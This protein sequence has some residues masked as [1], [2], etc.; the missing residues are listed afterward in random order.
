MILISRKLKLHEKSGWRKL[1][2][3]KKNFWG[4][5]T[6]EISDKN[7]FN[8][9]EGKNS[10][11]KELEAT[12]SLFFKADVSTKCNFIAR[13]EWLKKQLTLKKKKLPPIKCKEFEK[14][15]Q[16]I[17][18][19]K[20]SIVF[21]FY[22]MDEPAS[23][24]G[25]TFLRLYSSKRGE[26][27]YAVSYIANV[28][29]ENLLS[30]IFKGIFGGFQ[31]SFHI[32]PFE[33]Q[34]NQYTNIENRSVWEYKL[35]LSERETSRLLMH[36]WELS[37]IHFSYFFFDRN[38]SYQL[39]TLI[40]TARPFLDISSD[41]LYAVQPLDTVKTLKKNNLIDINSNYSNYFPSLWD[42]YQRGVSYLTDHEIEYLKDIL[43]RG[44]LP[45]KK[46][47][48]DKRLQVINVALKY[49]QYKNWKTDFKDAYY[50]KLQVKLFVEYNLLKTESNS[51][52]NLSLSAS[53]KQASLQGVTSKDPLLSHNS[54]TVILSSRYFSNGFYHS[55]TIRPALKDFFDYSFGYHPYSQLLILSTNFIYYP[56]F[57]FKSLVLLD[58]AALYPVD[59]FFENISWRV[60]S[61]IKKIE[62]LKEN[63]YFFYLQ[64]GFGLAWEITDQLIFAVLANIFMASSDLFPYFFQAAPVFS[65][66]IFWDIYEKHRLIFA[67][68]YGWALFHPKYISKQLRYLRLLYHINFTK[69]FAVE[70]IYQSQ[71][72]FDTLSLLESLDLDLKI[73]GKIYF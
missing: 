25:H 49:I 50:K 21:A 2:R 68:E 70:I 38:C 39:L 17:S 71:I 73:Q 8:A 9:Y 16:K 47:N 3:Y 61:G 65:I 67:S 43:F 54:S 62:Y 60:S 40:E 48:L 6:S 34:L 63:E 11:Q 59:M 31:G 26:N 66:K 42:N 7:F 69:N 28:G 5:F 27:G 10:P 44:K 29:E 14:W 22:D 45:S 15:Y 51:N 4:G 12:L 18:S 46:L 19:K 37:F 23:L 52:A 55:F 24:F 13:Y 35:N 30:Y 41:F 72:K 1:V 56:M 57:Q 36:L 64:P 53:M 32:K 33:F 58:I 20:I